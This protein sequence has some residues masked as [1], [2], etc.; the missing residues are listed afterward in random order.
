MKVVLIVINVW[1]HHNRQH[2][3]SVKEASRISS[4]KKTKKIKE[5]QDTSNRAVCF[6]AESFSNSIIL[7]VTSVLDDAAATWMKLQQK[8]AR[9]SE[10][11]HEQAQKVLMHFQHQETETADD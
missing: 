5:F 3:C 10:M 6:L 11:G 8:I 9:K 1:D 4:L 2:F 7:T